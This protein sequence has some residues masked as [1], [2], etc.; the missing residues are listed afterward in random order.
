MPINWRISRKHLDGQDGTHEL[1]LQEMKPMFMRIFTVSLLWLLAGCAALGGADPYDMQFRFQGCAGEWPQALPF[2]PV[3]EYRE[4]RG[5]QVY[6]VK[7]P[8]DC[9]LDKARKPRYKITGDTL[10][11]SYE[12][13]ADHPVAAC[14]CEYNS[15]FSFA[16]LPAQRL[17]ASFESRN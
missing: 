17:K 13:Y 7:A 2:R 14:L 9:G 16:G 10:A 4:E 5:R 12:L 15:E 6:H 8:D 1:L 3:I 11:L